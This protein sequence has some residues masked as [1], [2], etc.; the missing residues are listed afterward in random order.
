[1]EDLLIS[2]TSSLHTDGLEAVFGKINISGSK[3]L[4]VGCVYIDNPTTT[5]NQST[6]RPDH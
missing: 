4:H 6:H 3:T 1:M 5:L 2:P